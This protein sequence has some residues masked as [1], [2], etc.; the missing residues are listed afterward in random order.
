MLSD[1]QT[2]LLAV[3]TLACVAL[4]ILVVAVRVFRRSHLT[5]AQFPIYLFSWTITRV[6]WRAT[7]EGRVSLPKGQGAV[8]VSNHIGPVDPAFFTLVC[9]RPVHWMVAREYV[10]HAL[11]AWAF[12]VL[13]VIPVNRRGIDTAST[14]LSMRYAKRGD[15]VGLFPEGRI[16][17][18]K[19]LLL[20]GRPGAAMIALHARVPVIPCYLTGSPN[21]GTVFGF[22]FMPARVHLKIGQPLDI[23]EFYDRKGNRE[24]LEDLTRVFLQEIAKLAGEPDFK[25]EIAGRQWR[26]DAN[27]L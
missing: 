22:F 6:L 24:V 13:Q 7:V 2:K 8:I 1:D 16:N 26:R 25:A 5:L 14:K 19:K 4:G 9:D 11:Y 21:D 20:P 12:R 3:A 17:E 15:L 18:T 27:G 10:E 23:S